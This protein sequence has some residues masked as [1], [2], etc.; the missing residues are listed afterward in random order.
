[1]SD[2]LSFG[3]AT[4]LSILH[5]GQETWGRVMSIGLTSG[6]HIYYFGQCKQELCFS[7][8]KSDFHQDNGEDD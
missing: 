8:Y 6:D 2:A 7:V 5:G 1:M 3:T 4:L